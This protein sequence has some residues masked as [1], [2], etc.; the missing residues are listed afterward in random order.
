MAE[1]KDITFRKLTA[2]EL[3]A[4]VATVTEKGCSVLV[5]KDARVDQRVLDETVG[6]MNWQRD[7]KELK[8]NIYCAIGIWDEKKQQWIWK[9][10]CGSESNTEKEKG[11]ASDSFKRAGFNWGIGRELYTCPFVWFKAAD[12]N[13]TPKGNGY[14]TKDPFEVN[15]IEYDGNK[16]S[17]LVITNKKTKKQFVWGTP[18]RA[19]EDLSPA[20]RKKGEL[21]RL[22]MK[23][24]SD[25]TLFLIWCNKEFKR[26]IAA[27]DELNEHELDRAIAKVKQKENR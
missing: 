24:D 11:E 2:D 3:E 4:R 9:W 16:V 12:V 14:T 21:K 20:D 25:V 18:Q 8:G 6:A 26:E 15:E 13:I 1:K 10:D 17:F 27:V 7:H 19:F 22:L 23:T 5:Y